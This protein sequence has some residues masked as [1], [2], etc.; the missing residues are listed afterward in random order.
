MT[1]DPRWYSDNLPAVPFRTQPA[2]TPPL[3]ASLCNLTQ[4]T[5]RQFDDRPTPENE[6]VAKVRADDGLSAADWPS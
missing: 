6:A 4:S 2:I 1:Y 5:Y 3:V